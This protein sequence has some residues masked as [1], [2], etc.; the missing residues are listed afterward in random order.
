VNSFQRRLA[1]IAFA[2]ILLKAS[3]PDVTWAQVVMFGGL[4]MATWQ[5]WTAVFRACLERLLS[6]FVFYL[7]D[8]LCVA[9]FFVAYRVFLYK[10]V[11][12]LS[13]LGI[14]LAFAL[15]PLYRYRKLAT[16]IRKWKAQEAEKQAA[17]R[18]GE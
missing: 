10:P 15:L 8:T 2:A 3:L 7:C 13:A 4:G 11:G 6:A 18:S 17:A 12:L 5:L 1:F 9:L 14:G 16:S